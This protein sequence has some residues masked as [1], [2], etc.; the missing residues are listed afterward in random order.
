MGIVNISVYGRQYQVACDPGQEEHLRDLGFE[1]DER[2]R[3]MSRSMDGAGEHMILLL[4]SLMLADELRDVKQEV[5]YLQQQYQQIAAQAQA[6][7]DLPQASG[8]DARLLEME[9][10]MA[11]TLQEV[12]MRIER[13]A[14]QIEMR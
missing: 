14:E 10:A 4:S 5:A 12:A 7:Q 11:E 1:I 9:A 2:M 3:A 6:A 13:I 8:H